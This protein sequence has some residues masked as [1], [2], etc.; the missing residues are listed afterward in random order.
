MRSSA[1]FAAFAVRGFPSLK[2]T[3]SCSV[4]VHVS[5]SPLCVHDLASSGT[6]FLVVM[7]YLVSCSYMLFMAMPSL[8]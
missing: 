3:P 4:K 1:A 6:T 2:L 7:S 8:E 5:P